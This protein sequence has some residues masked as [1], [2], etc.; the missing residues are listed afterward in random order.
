[1]HVCVCVD[2]RVCMFIQG[3]VV[4]MKHTVVWVISMSVAIP[5][6]N[7]VIGNYYPSLG[8]SQ[9]FLIWCCNTQ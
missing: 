5:T 3:T 8:W 2:T 7:I 4:W 1:M 6:D 9:P